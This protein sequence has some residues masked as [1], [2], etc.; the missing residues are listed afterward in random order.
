MHPIYFISRSLY[1][2]AMWFPIMASIKGRENF[3]T[4]GGFI[5]ASNHISY[6]DPPI[7]GS[8]A[9]RVV[10][11]LAKK[12]LFNSGWF[13]YLLRSSNTHPL[14]RGTGDLATI[15]LAIDIIKQGDGLV[16][17]PEGTRSRD[18]RLG[19]P[20]PGIGMIA[21]RAKCPIV[22]CYAVG[23][24]EFMR[25]LTFREKMYIHFGEPIT[26][27][28]MAAQPPGKEGARR[29][30]DETMARIARLQQEINL[31][32]SSAKR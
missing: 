17:F 21:R 19:K 15:R 32:H 10:H 29:I 5:L 9:P 18:G 6:S 12:E 22:P 7:V 20:K 25:C 1:R 4:K 3:P 31:P 8:C 27:E 13:S 23:Q 24:Q 26:P 30:A 11:F 14:A 28:W 16:I 2:I